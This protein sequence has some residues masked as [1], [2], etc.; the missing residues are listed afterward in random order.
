MAAQS[1]PTPRPYAV[2]LVFGDTVHTLVVLASGRDAALA[3]VLVFLK[4][5][6]DARNHY[7]LLC[8]EPF[9]LPDAAEIVQ[10]IFA[11]R[12]AQSFSRAR[13]IVSSAFG[14]LRHG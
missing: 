2:N 12:R 14:G 1:I 5:A 4:A 11:E 10:R 8:A 9:P 6:K 3:D 7:R 13:Q